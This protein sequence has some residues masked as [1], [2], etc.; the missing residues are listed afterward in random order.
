MIQTEAEVIATA[1][2]HPEFLSTITYL[3]PKMFY[4]VENGCMFWCIQ[5]LYE[6][7]ITNID[8]LN[9]SNAININSKVKARLDG[10]IGNLQEYLELSELAARDTLEEYRLIV[11]QV[12]EAAYKRDVKSRAEDLKRLCD[13]EETKIDTI[14]SKLTNIE[15]ELSNKYIIG[16]ETRTFGQ[17]LRGVWDEICS[18]RNAD[19]TVGFPSKIPTFNNYFTYCKGELVLLTA[20]MKKGKS[21]FFM[22]EIIHLCI[23]NGVPTL[24]IDTE[25]SDK[26]LLSRMAANMTGIEVDRVRSGKYSESE[27]AKLEEA[28]LKIE[29]APF[30]HEY[31]PDGF[32]QMKIEA[33]CHQWKNK[34]GIEFVVYDYFKCDDMNSS[35]YET[36]NK[37]G[38]MCDFF[39]NRIAGR[40]DI[41]VLAGAQLNRNNDVGSSDKLEM[42]CSTSIRWF[43]KD[44]EM[45]HKDGLDCGNYG[46]SITLNRN[47]GQTGEDDYIDINFKGSTMQITEAK[48]H[49]TGEM[50]FE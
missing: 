47:G 43:E 16:E 28:F 35:A 34:I 29:A 2:K 5:K 48:P 25:M 37:L 6:Q 15:E 44:A 13:N 23:N 33:L 20:R 45:L 30:I 31:M 36:F 17:K 46:A 19:G 49:K 18:S 11:N 12:V 27:K 8:A 10:A 7:G 1:I 4:E 42:Y 22:N 41:A 9:L 39:K 14:N 21:A 3:Q 40:M 38:A 24:M 26:L 32:N 50:P